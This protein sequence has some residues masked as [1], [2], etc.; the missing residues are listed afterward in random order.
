V[1]DYFRPTFAQSVLKL[2]GHLIGGS[3]LFLALAALAWLVG[4]LVA[5]M[6]LIHPFSPAI[7]TALHG[8]ELGIFCIDIGLTAIVLFVGA[9]RFI[10]E[11]AGSRI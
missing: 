10:R 11:I 5:K 8:V 9:K 2:V 7:Y 6:H 1:Q 4:Y 3:I